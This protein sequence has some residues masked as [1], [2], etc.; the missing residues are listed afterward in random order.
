MKAVAKERSLLLWEFI[1]P[2]FLRRRLKTAENIFGIQTIRR[3]QYGIVYVEI[4]MIEDS[5]SLV[6]T[7]HSLVCQVFQS[8]RSK[9]T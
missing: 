5:T 4:I 8:L 7:V 6:N 2:L 9:Y 3:F 1:T